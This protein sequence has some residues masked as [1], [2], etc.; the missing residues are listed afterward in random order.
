MERFGTNSATLSRKE[1][2]LIT[3]AKMNSQSFFVSHPLH[4]LMA[5]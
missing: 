1:S 4:S 3:R 5:S 2:A